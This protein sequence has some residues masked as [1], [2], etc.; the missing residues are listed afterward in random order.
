M[1]HLDVTVP[2]QPPE[3][4]GLDAHLPLYCAFFNACES[5]ADKP[6]C[7]AS[8]CLEQD[9]TIGCEGGNVDKKEWRTQLS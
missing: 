9:L 7:R 3:S 6:R 4:F 2:S 1:L 5:T 8:V